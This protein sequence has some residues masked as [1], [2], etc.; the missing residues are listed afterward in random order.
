MSFSTSWTNDQNPRAVAEYM[1]KKGIKTVYLIGPNYA[2]GKENL[3]G[4]KAAFK[5]KVRRRG[6]YQVAGPAR[7]LGRAVEGPRRQSGSGLHL[8]SGRGRRA[9]P[10]P[11]CAGRSAGQNPALHAPSSI[12]SLSLPRQKDAAVGVIRRCNG[13]ADLPNDAN[14]KFV[15]DFKAKFKS[16][17]SFYAA[18]TYDAA[19]ADRV[20]RST[21]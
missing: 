18:Q 15:S 21:P 1:N 7:L 6:L 13:R 17:P 10:Q 16:E 19:N 11:V 12:N 4:M 5:G 14:K 3:G 20:R 2:A 9:I 8:L